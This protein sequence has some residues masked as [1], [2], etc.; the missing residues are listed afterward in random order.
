[1]ATNDESEIWQLDRPNGKTVLAEIMLEVLGQ[2]RYSYII[3]FQG[4][5]RTR[6]QVST[7]VWWRSDRVALNR[8]RWLL[9][10]MGFVNREE[11]AR[12]GETKNGS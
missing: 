2:G 4:H 9:L 5:R 1:M 6:E 3:I 8:A 10:N 12:M 7:N 11:L